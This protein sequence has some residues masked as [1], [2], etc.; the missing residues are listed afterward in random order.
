MSSF[1]P[2]KTIQQ[3]GIDDHPQIPAQFK[4]SFNDTAHREI[5]DFS[6]PKGLR[7][8]SNLET[9]DEAR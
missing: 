7:R 3:G 5:N 1:E 4:R 8:S 2:V 9:L 6:R